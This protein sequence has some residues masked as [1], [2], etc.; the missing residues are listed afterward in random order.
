ME[1]I[2]PDEQRPTTADVARVRGQL[3]RPPRG[4]IGVAVRCAHG[5]PAVVRT[6]PIL[7]DGTP[8][9]TL[10][11]LTCPMASRAAGTLEASGRMS[12]LTRRLDEDA[13]LKEA[14][15]EADR[16]YRAQRDSIAVLAGQTAGGMPDRVK[17]LHA[18]VA[19]EFADGN[20]VG[21]LVRD[22]IE[23]TDCP[24]PCVNEDGA[25]V[26]RHPGFGGSGA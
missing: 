25:R 19:H 9:P 20:P 7:E 1:R 6:E 5:L 8:F 18:L 16:R 13:A 15:R 12:E 11:Y 3:G 14:Y 24:G 17:C 23:P 10:Y 2:A 21:G 22:E 26:E 4:E